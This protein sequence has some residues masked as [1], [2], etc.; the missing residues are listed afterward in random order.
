V[1]SPESEV[2]FRDSE[3]PGDEI[4]R[5]VVTEAQEHLEDHGHGTVL[6]SWVAPS[7]GHWSTP[8]RSWVGP[9]CD[10]VLFQFTSVRPL[11]YA[12]MWT[13]DV[14]R[15]LAYYSAT[16]IEWISTGAVILRRKP[17]GGR[18]VAFQATG[19][20]REN[21]GE[22]LLRIFAAHDDLAE[23]GGKNDGWLLAGRFRLAD[24]RL[25]QEA[26]YRDGSYTIELTG[27][28][29]SGSPLN[30]R[31]EPEAVHAIARLDGSATV[32]EAAQH[33]ARATGLDRGVAEEA[34]LAAIRRLYTRGFLVR[35]A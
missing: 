15:W 28:S 26:S 10:A 1:V 6:G 23:N 2:M 3:Y 30:A 22:Q 33:A 21:A 34:A 24:H 7:E 17:G 13:G 18:A 5:L 32:A 14:D 12:A 25:Q 16:G 20:P 19:A 8:L 35:D 27:V 29:I 4:S 11:Q 31:V 9:S